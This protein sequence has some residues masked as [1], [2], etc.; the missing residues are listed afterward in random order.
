MSLGPPKVSNDPCSLNT[1]SEA[2]SGQH[3]SANDAMAVAVYGSHLRPESFRPLSYYLAHMSRSDTN[4][5]LMNKKTYQ[6]F[7]VNQFLFQV[8]RHLVIQCYFKIIFSL[9]IATN[10]IARRH[11][12]ERAGEFK[13][14]TG[15][16]CYTL[17]VCDASIQTEN[18]FRFWISAG[19]SPHE[20]TKCLSN[21]H[22]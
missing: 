2:P 22:S 18:D 13:P 16:R 19:L 3:G 6:S 1:V 14:A 21:E 9:A 11:P 4:E 20:K 10:A 15:R 7:F 17:R 5:K 12:T 8:H